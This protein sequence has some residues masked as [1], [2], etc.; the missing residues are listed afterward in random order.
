MHLTKVLLSTFVHTAKSFQDNDDIWGFSF[1]NKDGKVEEDSNQNVHHAGNAT[2]T[3]HGQQNAVNIS[4]HHPNNTEELKSHEEHGE[5]QSE[6]VSQQ[7]NNENEGNNNNNNNTDNI[8]EHNPSN[9]TN[10][11]DVQESNHNDMT[12]QNVTTENVNNTENVQPEHVNNTEHVQ[13]EHVNN[14]EHVQHENINNTEHVQPEH[15]NNTEHVQPEHV[16]NTEHVQPEHVNN[17]EHVQHEN[18]NNTEH[19]QPEHVN[20]TEHVQPE[21]VNNT[22]HVQP[23][24]VN[25]TEHVQPENVNNTEHIQHENG[26]SGEEEGEHS[27]EGDQINI[28]NNNKDYSDV[29]SHSSSSSDSNQFSDTTS[30]SSDINQF[31]D[32]TSSSSDRSQF[33]D[34]TSSSSSG[35]SNLRKPVFGNGS[36]PVFGNP[37]A[38]VFGN[39]SA[40]VFGNPSAPVFGNNYGGHKG[41]SSTNFSFKDAPQG[42]SN[43]LYNYGQNLKNHINENHSDIMDKGM[44][45]I[46]DPHNYNLLKNKYVYLSLAERAIFEIMDVSK[47]GLSEI[48]SMRNREN[49]SKIYHSALKRLKMNVHSLGPRLELISLETCD[50][51]LSEMFKILTELSYDNYSQFYESMNINK[52]ALSE[53][54]KEIKIKILKKIGVSYAKFPPIIKETNGN[55]C[56]VSDLIISITPRE[57][58]QRLAIM[59]SGWLSADEYGSIDDFENNVELNVLCS[60][61]SI[62]MQQWKYYQNA[63]GFEDNNDHA[64]LGLIDELLTID[65]KYSKNEEHSKSLEKMKKSKVFNYCT[66]L[67]RTSGNISTIPFNHENNKTPSSSIV[68]S[69]GNL[70]KA[71]MS[72]YYAATAQRINSY[73]NYSDNKDKKKTLSKVISVCTLLNLTD[74]LFNCTDPQSTNAAN[75]NLLKLNVLNTKGKEIL[76]RLYNLSYLLESENEA[77]KEV[78]NPK[79]AAV[80]KSLQKLLELVSSSS[81]NVL[82]HEIE[83]RALGTDYINEEIKNINDFDHNEKDKG[84]DDVEKAIFDDL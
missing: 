1:V 55:Q 40:P 49:I 83:K 41:S 30:S 22:E 32:T 11:S 66:K 2:N 14:T 17:T 57:L 51:I 74:I 28:N 80:D 44:N 68:G 3:E 37:S 4:E 31:S 24:Y 61:A 27:A 73:F 16:N 71:H 20:N 26:H 47:K 84:E 58:S 70:V 60:G 33:S 38:P 75:L 65:K 50:K 7:I 6:Q 54:F 45:S 12:H 59:F 52:S 21:Y 36:R 78:C 62:L 81:H 53:S 35:Y 10:N 25:N 23:E 46:T 5:G 18:I 79:N 76:Y 19:V 48:S 77:I 82:T 34:T 8:P 64:F 56:P 69:L 67:M 13:P 15:V 39:P 9:Q 43:M 42:F 63:L 29:Y 72:G